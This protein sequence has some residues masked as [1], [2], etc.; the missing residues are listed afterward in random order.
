MTPETIYSKWRET[1][2]QPKASIYYYHP[3]LD[4]IILGLS[5]YEIASRPY[6]AKSKKLET[7]TLYNIFINE[8]VTAWIDETAETFEYPFQMLMKLSEVYTYSSQALRS[9]HPELK[10]SINALLYNFLF[11]VAIAGEMDE[12]RAEELLD[13]IATD[14]K[15]ISS[16]QISQVIKRFQPTILS[17]GLDLKQDDVDEILRSL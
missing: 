6:L 4:R 8:M 15:R 3:S 7:L 2:K 16:E 5:M 10:K 14:G 17:K 11:W 1:L 13:N 12:A 9:N